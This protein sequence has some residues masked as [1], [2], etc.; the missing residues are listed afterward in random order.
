MQGS[1]SDLIS[2]QFRRVTSEHLKKTVGTE[3]R[4]PE[5]VFLIELLKNQIL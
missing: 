3:T 5:T 1:F 4:K 2:F